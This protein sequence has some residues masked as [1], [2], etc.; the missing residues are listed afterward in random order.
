M[1][2]VAY[3]HAKGYIQT[4]LKPVFLHPIKQPLPQGEAPN[5]DDMELALF[6]GRQLT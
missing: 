6:G 2:A 3:Q 5:P 1:S 4:L